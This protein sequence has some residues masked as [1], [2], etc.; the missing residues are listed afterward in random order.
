MDLAR[1]TFNFLAARIRLRK[2]HEKI[3]FIVNVARFVGRRPAMEPRPGRNCDARNSR[4]LGSHLQPARLGRDDEKNRR[5]RFE[6]RFRARGARRE[7]VVSV[8]NFAD[9]RLGRRPMEQ[10]RR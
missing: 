8:E 10:R 2:F 7:C 5:C 4:H 6:L 1:V 3:R 9:G